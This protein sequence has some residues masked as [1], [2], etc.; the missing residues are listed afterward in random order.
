MSVKNIVPRYVFRFVDSYDTRW[1]ADY[2]RIVRDVFDYNR[3][4]PN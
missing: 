4:C 3:I 1:Y 2:N